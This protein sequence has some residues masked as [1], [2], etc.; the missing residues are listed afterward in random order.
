[1]T[2]RDTI[3]GCGYSCICLKGTYLVQLV[4]ELAA[5]AVKALLLLTL[6]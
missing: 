3:F 1:M 6:P 4:V 5:K 2:K